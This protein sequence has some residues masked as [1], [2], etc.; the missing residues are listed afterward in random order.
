MQYEIDLRGLGQLAYQILT[1]KYQ[2]DNIRMAVFRLQ[3][4]CCI[5]PE[6]LSFCSLESGMQSIIKIL[7]IFI[8]CFARS[9]ANVNG[10]I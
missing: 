7:S 5:R 8:Q 9:L 4:K 3:R 10:V 2:V 6:I 1:R